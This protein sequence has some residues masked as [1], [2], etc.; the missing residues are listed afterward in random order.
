[1]STAAETW[2]RDLGAWAIPPGILALAS[3]SP[4]IHPPVLFEVPD[5]I[6]TSPS[7]ERARE[8]L[9]ESA[10]V[11]DVGCGGGI[12]AFALTP[13]A[14]HVVGVDHQDEMLEMFTRN[15]RAR[16]LQV[17][18]HLG[19][20]PALASEVAVADVVTSHHVVYNVADIVPF[21]RE[22]ND[23]ATRRVVLELPR[24]HP[25]ANLSDAWRHFWQLERPTR[26]TPDDL[27]AVV[28][29][30]GIEASMEFW[31]GPMRV[32]QDLVQAAHF[33]R[34]RLC[35]PEERE[36]EVLEYLKKNPPASQRELATVWWDV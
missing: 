2:A 29:E 8:V 33:T 18:T 9:G 27:M 22:L 10:T 30:M 28:A 13:P 4:W 19:F 17:Q 26:P 3:E 24:Q 31:E 6:T 12:A 23:H 34:V 14:T 5:V 16:G 21:V 7:H 20:W 32:E 35:L 36:G 25:L 1:M 15:A 11:L